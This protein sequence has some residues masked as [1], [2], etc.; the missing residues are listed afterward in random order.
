MI[1]KAVARLQGEL[2]DQ[3]LVRPFAKAPSPTCESKN[4]TNLVSGSNWH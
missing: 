1:C 3:E 4:P 2:K